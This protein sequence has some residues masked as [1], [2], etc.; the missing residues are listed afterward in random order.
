MALWQTGIQNGIDRERKIETMKTNPNMKTLWGKLL[1]LGVGLLAS[2]L[3]AQ[4]VITNQ[5]SN[6]IVIYGGNATFS[7]MVTGVGPFTYQWQCNGTN[8]PNNI[9]S[10]IAGNGNRGYAGDG[11]LAVTSQLY[12]AFGLGLDATGN[13][14]VAD[15]ENNRIRRMDLNGIITTAVGVG[16]SNPGVGGF[17]GDGGAATNASLNLPKG[18]VFDQSGN[19]Y[20]ADD[21]NFRIRKVDANGVI[22]TVAGNGG[23]GLTGDGGVATNATLWHP[24]GLAVDLVGNLFI[25]DTFNNC[26]RK[27][28]TNGNISTIAG[29]GPTWPVGGSYSGDGGPATNATLN[30]PYGVALDRAGNVYIAD[31]GNNRIRKVDANGIII[32]VAGNGNLYYTG[33]GGP[34]TNATLYAPHSIIIDDV[35]N[36]YIADTYNNRLRKVDTNGIISTIAGNGYGANGSGG[37]AFSGDGGAATNASLWFPDGIVLDPVG[38]V[39]F[40]DGSNHR[41]RAVFFGGK[42]TLTMSNVNL[43]N[44]GNYSVIVSNNFGSVTSVVATMTVVLP[45]SIIVQP[46]SQGGSNAT[47]TVTASG[48]PPLYYTWYGNGT[49]LLQSGT[50][51]SLVVGNAESLHSGNYFVIIT[52]NYGS[53]TSQIARVAFPPI[54]A[55][56]PTSQTVISGKTFTWNVSMAGTGPF[57]YQWQ[58]NGTNLPNNIITTVAGNGVGTYA[59]D[60]GLATNASIFNST[61]V[62]ADGS[63][64][65]LIADRNS[66]RIRRVNTNGIIN[67]VAGT[68]SSGF[69]GDS[70]PA[71]I[72][73]LNG[74]Y[75]VAFDAWGNYFIADTGNN[76]IR[77]VDTNGVITT[78]A[79]N[80]TAGFGGDG[81]AAT[82]AA[83]NAPRGMA[84]DGFGNLFIA[85]TSNNRIRLVDTNGNISTLAGTN[86]AGVSGDGGL[87]VVAKLGAPQGVALDGLGNVFI[88]DYNNSRIRRVDTNGVITTFAGTNVS[89]FL[90][91]GGIATVAR[92]ANPTGV[93]VDS[94]GYVFF[95]DYNNN[96][97]R[98]VDLNGIIT[99]VAGNGST[100]YSGDGGTSTNATLYQ[101][102]GVAVESSGSLLIAD[103]THSRIRRTTIGRIPTLSFNSVTTNNAGSNYQVIVSSPYGSVTSSVVSLTVVFAPSI[104][105][106]PQSITVTNGDP[107]EFDV[108]ATSTETLGYQWYRN[109]MAVDGGT[110]AALYFPQTVFTQAGNYT[111]IITTA[112]GSVTSSVAILKVLGVPLITGLSHRYPFDTDVSDLIGGANGTVLGNACVT[113]G[114]LVLDGTNS[115]VRLPNDLFTSYDSISFEVWYA[116]APVSNPNNQLYNFSRAGGGM[117][118]CLFGQGNHFIGS[119]SN[120]VTLP[121]PAVGGTNHLIWTQDS[122]SQTARIFINGMLAAQ[123]TSFI[124]T[125]AMIGSTTNNLIGAGATNLAASNF[126]GSILEFRT[127]NRALSPLEAAVLDA[128]GPDQPQ[129]NP[130]TLQGVRLVIPSPTGPGAL[131]HAGVFADFSGITNVN[132]STQPDLVLASDNTNVITIAPDQRLQTMVLGTANIT[133]IWQGF[134]NTVPVTVGVPQDIALIHRYGFNEQTNDWIVHDSIGGA[135]GRLFNTGS[136]ASPNAV[137]TGKGE[138]KLTGGGGGGS[139]AVLGYAAL[140]LG[141]ISSMSEVTVEAWVT[142]TLETFWPWQRIFDFGNN[143]GG[144]QASGVTYFFLT[145]EA[146]TFLTSS[147]DLARFTISTNGISA[148]SPRLNWINI[149]PLNVTSYVAVTYSPVRGITKFY[150]NGQL[151]SSGKAV[152]PLSAIIDTNNWLGR[153]QYYGDAYFG[154]RYNEFRVYRGLLS[155]ADVAADYAA[156]PDAVGVDYVLHNYPMTNALTITWGPSATN[157][158]LQSS[159]VLGPGAVWTPVPLTPALQ[160]GRYDVTVSLTNDATFF[161][162]HTP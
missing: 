6:Q 82:S 97:V 161:R 151:I 16:P 143:T 15:T 156:G 133:A 140:P 35:G 33:N 23:Y 83:I 101:P 58:F 19:L 99:T 159:P 79:G 43:A 154:G 8:L 103:M 147:T 98:R 158:V 139:H 37:G 51:A 134:S 1:G 48:T 54:I 86:A 24:Y 160:N 106:Q 14:Y 122:T 141:I 89:G 145:T 36:L 74:P 137:F 61:G 88:A 157:L 39:Y 129:L 155:D 46:F 20:F 91:D 22:T 66:N 42:P 34:A 146:N 118:G 44:A 17:G 162:L 95:S 26:V 125:P 105:T 11:G 135:S 120:L 67:T 5:P 121:I 144:S 3:S 138:M 78:V 142:W 7:V 18:A 29:T 71:N 149:L 31:T 94:Y 150:L 116:D 153:S 45:P 76:R 59:G 110:N 130:G 72:A 56:P 109:A 13:L 55:T 136:T 85:D 27:V 127:Y 112:Y 100:S 87:A 21:E 123:N 132:L 70:G 126:K 60:S 4:P 119:S 68:N 90:G 75:G 96:R 93:A 117:Y 9:I 81:A 108:V 57:T 47:V 107:A 41:L 30:G 104:S 50:N 115:S 124:N 25:A 114:S 77:K 32:T 69:A 73:K 64:N 65:F 113:N 12:S 111:C 53:I 52:N 62:A 38:N 63:G 148:E 92:L 80:G 128:Y 102:Y 49:N 40:T 152:I 84:V 2:G 28:D 10:T 131:F